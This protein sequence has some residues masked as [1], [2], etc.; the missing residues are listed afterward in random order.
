MDGREGECGM[1]GEDVVITGVI[2]RKQV[3]TF[4]CLFECHLHYESLAVLSSRAF[5]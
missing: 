3:M 4:T 1:R 2:I 5:L